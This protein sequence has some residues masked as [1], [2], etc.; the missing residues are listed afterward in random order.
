M[1]CNGITLKR[2]R[3]S[4]HHF[5]LAASLR[6][7]PSRGASPGHANESFYTSTGS[8]QSSAP[9]LSGGIAK[10]LVLPVGIAGGGGGGAGAGSSTFVAGAGLLPGKSVISVQ[11]KRLADDVNYVYDRQILYTNKIQLQRSR[12]EDLTFR[13]VKAEKE[14]VS[15]V[16]RLT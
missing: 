8:Q 9:V 16:A 3:S 13:I 12:I 6:Q 1:V 14:L 5:G 7:E 11:S 15:L 10:G 4:Y 2:Q